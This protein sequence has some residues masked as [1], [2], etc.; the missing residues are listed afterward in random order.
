MKLRTFFVAAAILATVVACGQ[1]KEGSA[2]TRALLPKSA[3]IDSVSYLIGVNFGSFIKNY[4]FGE[5]LNYG[6]IEKGIKAYLN[7]KG[8]PRDSA[9]AEQF[10]IDP[11]EMERL[12][13]SFLAKRREYT[14]A[15]NKEKE[16]AFLAANLKKNGVMSTE[17]GLQYTIIE[18]GNDVKPGP[19]DTV[20]VN[21]K[22][23]LPDGTV[24]DE[25]PEGSKPIRM[26]LDRVI[27][28]WTEGLQLIGEG[29]KI[30]LVIP[31]ELAYGENGTRGIEP[32]TPLTFEVSLAEVK[33]FVEKEE[34][35][36]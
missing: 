5:D 2:E 12:F 25:T 17:S 33:P 14:T 19:Q 30:Q 20:Y 8:N 22:G 32:N 13:N 35:A 21:Y 28:G 29:G 24:F 6:Q 34:E 7:A 4:N 23:T 16:E 27:K 18:A 1:K 3:E 11:N 9:F 10:K 31:S 26:Q 36:K 15:L